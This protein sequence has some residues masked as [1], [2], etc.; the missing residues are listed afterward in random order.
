MPWWSLG[1]SGVVGFARVRP[2][3]RC[4]HLGSFGSL[5]FAL[6]IVGL[7]RSR[8]IDSRSLWVSSG[9]SWVVC[10][11]LVRRVC[12]WFHPWW[13]GSFRSALGV[14][15]FTRVHLGVR[16]VHPESLGSPGFTLGVVGFIR[17]S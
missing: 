4:V 14:V 2:G 15:G 6:G 11:T 3:C 9:S 12:C 7:I 16:S 5:V 8:W 1:S 17:G 10:F 13:L